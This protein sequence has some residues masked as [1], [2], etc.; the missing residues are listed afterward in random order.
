MTRRITSVRFSPAH[1]GGGLLGFA[2]FTLDGELAIDG[3]G[4]RRSLTGALVL[5]WPARKDS[6]GRRHFHVRPVDD[7]V[8]RELENELFAHL[9]PFLRGGAP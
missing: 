2:S 3:V 5:S 8:R 7:G 1:T 4:V 9:H 6:A